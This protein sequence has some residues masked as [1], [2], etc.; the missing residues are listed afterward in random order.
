M[1]YG[2]KLMQ[3]KMRSGTV[4]STL[5]DHQSVPQGLHN[6]SDSARFKKA[7][8][9]EQVSGSFGGLVG[10]SSIGPDRDRQVG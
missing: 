5:N 7:R 6:Y 10:K 2:L 1:K 3:S 8:Y 4:L 9:Q